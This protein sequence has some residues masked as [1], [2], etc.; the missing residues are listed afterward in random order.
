MART[1]T[2]EVKFT[3]DTRDLQK[4]TGRVEGELKGVG[5]KVSGFAVGAG[6]ALT[7]MGAQAIPALVNFGKELFSLGQSSEIALAKSETVFGESAG[8]IAKWADGV[9]ESLGLSDETVIGLAA[10]MGDLL[11]P[12]G[13]TREAAADM[14]METT[15]LSGA[16]SAWSQGQYDA[17]EVSAILTK[18]ML[19][20]R[21]GL[22]ALGISI[23]QAEVDEKALAL[24][25]LDG[26][27]AVTAQDKALATQQLILEKS[28]DA[29]AAWSDGTMDAVKQQNELSA[30]IADAKEGLAKG[31]V[32]VIQKVVKWIVSDLVPAVRRGVETFKR[33]WPQIKAA[34]LPTM[35]SIK[36]IVQTVLQVVSELWRRYG[37]DI[38]DKVVGTFTMIKSLIESAMQVIQ[39]IIDVVVGI[40]SGDWSRAWDGIK[41][42]FEGVWDAIKAVLSN[43]LDVLKT[44]LAIAWEGIKRVISGAWD[45][46][47]SAVR[48]YVSTMVGIITKIP[49]RI[50]ATIDGLWSGIETGISTAMDWVSD[51]ID[52]IVSFATGLPGRMV[53]VF[54]GMWDGI[55]EAFRSTLN[56][57]IRKWNDL[58]FTIP[59]VSVFG[60]KLGGT[61]IGTPNIAYL[62][63]GGL[64]F[65][66]RLSLVGDNLGAA[67][68]PEVVAP[69]SKLAPMLVDALATSLALGSSRLPT[70]SSSRSGSTTI[71]Q[72]IPVGVNP[73]NVTQANRQYARTQ[74]PL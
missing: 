31:L 19:G 7:T 33:Y 46:I 15:E 43:A 24:A 34:V 8:T 38:I 70:S 59:S 20:E 30:T 23:S 45:G 5:S 61:T 11:V 63:R 64:A 44:L 25:K 18:A 73:V 40:I 4:A 62:A 12:L 65:G 39:G 42:I 3:G 49:S 22:K 71:I 53:G 56:W 37:S 57:I 52:D 10:S 9:N 27:D 29:Q 14:A 26:R 17:E 35:N 21:D 6:A 72:N 16:L 41:A 68:D 67:N 13:F 66:P 69:L 28:T 2:I 58:S 48:G 1:P 47:V 50:W 60:K 54:V 36:D 74:G 51:R 55:K 32:P